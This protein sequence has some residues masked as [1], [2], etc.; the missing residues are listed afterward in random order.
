MGNQLSENLFKSI[1]TIVSARMSNLPYDQ[2]LICYVSDNIDKGIYQVKYESIDM[3]AYSDNSEYQLGDQVY[4]SIPRGDYTQK[5]I[6]LGKVP[7]ETNEQIKYQLFEN[8]VPCTKNFNED[9]I[10]EKPLNIGYDADKYSIQIFSKL[11][12]N[13]DEIYNNAGYNLMRVKLGIAANLKKDNII[14]KEGTYH[15]DIKI[16]YFDQTNSGQEFNS[17]IASQFSNASYEITFDDMISANY[18]DTYG[19]CSQGKTFDIK[20]KVIR[21]IDIFLSHDKNFKD[22]TGALIEAKNDLYINYKDVE[23]T[24][25]YAGS[26]SQYNGGKLILYTVDGLL[27]P[28]N[29]TVTKHFYTRLIENTENGLSIFTPPPEEY[30]NIIW[31][32]F[33]PKTPLAHTTFQDYYTE[34][35]GANNLN[36]SINIE[37]NKHLDK[38]IFKIAI[39]KSGSDEK[40]LISNPLEFVNGVDRKDLEVLNRITGFQ[41]ETVGDNGGIFNIYGPDNLLLNEAEGFRN[42]SLRLSY[43]SNSFDRELMAGD[44]IRYSFPKSNTMILPADNEFKETYEVVLDDDDLQDNTYLLNYKIKSFYNPNYTSNNIECEVEIQNDNG[45]NTILKASKELLFGTS[46]SS[47]SDYIFSL[48]LCDSQTEVKVPAIVKGDDKEYTIIPH[49][50]DYSMKEISLSNEITWNWIDG[51]DLTAKSDIDK[52]SLKFADIE[53]KAIADRIIVASIGSLGLT[54][55]LPIAVSVN[56]DS[57]IEGCKTIVYDVTGK[58]PI[59]YKQKYSFFPKVPK[60]GMQWVLYENGGESS[61]LQFQNDAIIPPSTYPSSVIKAYCNYIDEDKNT[62]WEQPILI[63][64]NKYPSPMQNEELNPTSIGG[65]TIVENMVGEVSKNADSMSGLILGHLKKENGSEDSNWQLALSAFHNNDVMFMISPESG[66]IIAKDIEGAITN[67]RCLIDTNNEKITVGGTTIPIYFDDGTPVAWTT[68]IGNA[69]TPIYFS[70][71]NATAWTTTIGDVNTP[72]YFDN[73]SATPCSAVTAKYYLDGE[74]LK[75]I[76]ATFQTMQTEIND[77]KERITAL[78]ENI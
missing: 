69:N 58:K 35:A 14:V 28:F 56:A 75:E 60:E 15:V 59:Y 46:G 50:Y 5:K 27:Y 73:G 39:A 55:Y 41:I 25:G 44:K 77:L 49:L 34:I 43:V 51:N 31:G 11:F 30:N 53:G 23:V 1:D 61:F 67:A 52:F 3:V 12:D 13:E 16:E 71:G 76:L 9:S 26:P 18:Y 72:I 17:I 63:I 65:W 38:A 78:E 4:V 21:S 6:I 22:E 19:F 32:V 70:E 7:M 57:Y 24:F 62:Y 20:N 29:E 33:D 45:I 66:S 40:Y 2:T 68:T 10:E 37:K 74:D 42:H 54:A 8:Y 36:E 47:G 48:E 64:K